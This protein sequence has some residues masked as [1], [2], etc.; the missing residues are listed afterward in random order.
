MC[1]CVECVGYGHEA[2]IS[3]CL[4]CGADSSSVPFNHEYQ[5]C[6]SCFLGVID[7]VAN[8]RPL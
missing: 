2:E 6:E 5:L 3:L 8:E 7:D 4:G 1:A